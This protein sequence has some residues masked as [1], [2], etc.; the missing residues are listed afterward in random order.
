MQNFVN[1]KILLKIQCKEIARNNIKCK[2]KKL[3]TLKDCK[4]YQKYY[5]YFDEK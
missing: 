1:D 2:I 5:V 4:K 3:L